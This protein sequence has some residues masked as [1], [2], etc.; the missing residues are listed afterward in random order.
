[1]TTRPDAHQRTSPPGLRRWD[2]ER[3]G[4]GSSLAF[5]IASPAA[6]LL[7]FGGIQFGL[8]SYARDLALSAA[9]TGVRAAAAYPADA[10]RGRAATE[11]YLANAAATSLTGTAVTVNL[12]G[13]DVTVT[14]TGNGPGLVPG[15]VFDVSEQA[16]AAVEPEPGR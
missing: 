2:P 14:V 16:A 11:A 8:H 12:T 7:V 10:A 9:Q 13:N 4:G 6:L 15:L 3:G 1:M 5:L